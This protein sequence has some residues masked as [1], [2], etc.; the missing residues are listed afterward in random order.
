VLDSDL[1]I[2]FATRSF[3]ETFAVAPEDAVGRK[4]YELG[5][6]QW[7]I[8]NSALSLETIISGDLV[9]RGSEITQTHAL[10]RRPRHGPVLAPRQHWFAGT[11]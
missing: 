1:A 3:C 10:L 4:L 5:N 8:P 2:R 11:L 7:D 9:L 6:G